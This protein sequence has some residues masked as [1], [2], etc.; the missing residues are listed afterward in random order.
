MTPNNYQKLAMR[1][2]SI[3]HN[4]KVG[5][6]YHAIFGLNSEAGEVAGI[7][8]KKYQGHKVDKVHLKKE[9]GDCCW[10]IAEACEALGFELEDVMQTN[11]DKLK[12][13]FPEGFDVEK[14][15]H[16]ASGDI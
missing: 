6:L 9:L 13:R 14:D 8:Q 7:L 15:L 16:R 5:M 1:T 3:P 2:C 12:K 11:I 10:M 4:D